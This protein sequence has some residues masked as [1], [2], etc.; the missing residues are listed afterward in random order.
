MTEKL[1]IL[2]FFLLALASCGEK[3]EPAQPEEKPAFQLQ[4]ASF[5]DLSGWKKDNIN[6]AVEAFK[7]S[8]RK[9]LQ[10]KNDYMSY[11][12]TRIPVKD[13]QDVCQ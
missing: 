8:C 6:Q 9:I 1:S 13:Y 3:K 4:K 5:S 10:E 12:Q 2:F 7:K 11:A